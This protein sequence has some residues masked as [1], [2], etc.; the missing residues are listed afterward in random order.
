MAKK[1]TVQRSPKGA[2]ST[3]PPT[4]DGVSW[5][6]HAEQ[7]STSWLW[8][9][10][11]PAHCVVL[12]EGRKAT[13]KSTVAASIAASIT[14]GP[15]LPGW[16]GPRDRR[17]LWQASED[18]WDSVV[19]PRL[20][21]AKADLSRIGRS[22]G[23]Q[24]QQRRRPLSLPDDMLFLRDLIV[25]TQAGLLVL[26]PYISLA[27][28]SIDIRVEQQARSYLDALASV[29]AET[30]CTCLLLRHLRKGRGGDARESGLGSVAVANAARSILR[31]DEHPDLPNRWVL[32]VVASNYG[33]RMPTQIY[34]IITAKEGYPSVSWHGGCDLDADTIAEGR[35]DLASRDEYSDAE[36]VLC[37]AIGSEYVRAALVISE[38]GR[39]GVGERTLRSAK[40][41]LRVP[42]VRVTGGSDAWWEWGPPLYG[43]PSG[44]L[45]AA[46]SP[47]TL[48]R[49][50]GAHAPPPEQ[51]SSEGEGRVCALQPT[52]TTQ[53]ANAMPNGAGKGGDHA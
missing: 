35:G 1:K 13:G 29:A 7:V 4:V 42:S 46:H 39:A 9:G 40:A 18:A 32:S 22:E 28:S 52:Q 25:D 11:I 43:W 8:P 49:L 21:A 23:I 47:A 53:D 45:E 44:L 38:A 27:H 37:F 50:Q 36:R 15:T 24:Q 33:K 26:D 10:A 3:P 20:A 2:L 31:C 6:M 12:L 34:E 5:A 14:G 30:R 17:V 48:Q 19:V 51:K 41:R 16:I